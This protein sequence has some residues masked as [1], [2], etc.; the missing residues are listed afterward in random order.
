MSEPAETTET[1][2]SPVDP[3][4]TTGYRLALG[5]VIFLGLLIIVG[6]GVLIVGLIKG[7]GS[8]GEPAAEQTT[9]VSKA[10]VSMELAP[11]FR[12]LSSDT[13]PGRLILHVRSETVDEIDVIDLHDGRVVARIHAEAPK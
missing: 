11:G 6:V 7:W 5:S 8:K 1:T 2:E 10:P 3:K 9:D 12:I 4:S 13:Q